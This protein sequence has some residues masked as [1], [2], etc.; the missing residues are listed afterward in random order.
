M[1]K[2][3]EEATQGR[4]NAEKDLHSLR[5]A[6]GKNTNRIVRPNQVELNKVTGLIQKEV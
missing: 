3:N 4:I 2:V 6:V 1:G 5:E